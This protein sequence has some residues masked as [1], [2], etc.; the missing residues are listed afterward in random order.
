MVTV[1][2]NKVDEKITFSKFTASEVEILR[3]TVVWV[4]QCLG[5]D[6]QTRVG[7]EQCQANNYLNAWPDVKRSATHADIALLIHNSLNEVLH[8]IGLADESMVK[9]LGCNH[10]G[11]QG[12]FEKWQQ[13]R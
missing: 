3:K 6:Y 7:I 1:S 4:I 8:G 12:L 11:L 13:Q 9:E 5:S 10:E 2:Q